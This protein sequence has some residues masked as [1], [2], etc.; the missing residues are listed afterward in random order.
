MKCS[1]IIYG[2]YELRKEERAVTLEAGTWSDPESIDFYDQGHEVWLMEPIPNSFKELIS[3]LRGVRGFT[4]ARCLNAAI[5]NKTGKSII[6]HCP[7]LPGHSSLSHGEEHKEEL[8]SMGVETV[9]KEIEC[10]TYKY[11]IE[12]IIK[13]KV[14][15]LILD[16]EGYE[17]PVLKSMGEEVERNNL[18]DIVCIEC[19]Y[20]WQ[21]R[22][23]LLESMG[24][25]ADFFE[26]NNCYLSL[27]DSDS[28]ISKDKDLI[29]RVNQK[30]PHFYW[31]NQYIYKNHLIK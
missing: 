20:D 10:Y 7:G 23:E 30:N 29:S 3:S 19:G 25:G 2:A 8:N 1:K 27:K 6:K 18:P 15:I 9:E 17:A 12:S 28:I 14:N 31:N 4:Q 21:D 5:S 26:Y 16:I 22:L 13:K 11:L 24:Y